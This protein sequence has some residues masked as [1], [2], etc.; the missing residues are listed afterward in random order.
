M[1]ENEAH[2]EELRPRLKLLQAEGLV[3][4]NV[5]NVVRHFD[6]SRPLSLLFDI[7]EKV[8]SEAPFQ[9]VDVI[10]LTKEERVVLKAVVEHLEFTDVA[11]SEKINAPRQVISSMKK[12]LERTGLTK[13][14]RIVDLQK[15]GYDIYAFTDAKFNPEAPLKVRSEG[16]QRTIQ[17]APL[18]ANCRIPLL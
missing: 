11:L 5:K 17:E 6:Y 2:T 12:R 3:F 16:I 8:V 7:K 1:Q 4:R 15:L 9:K 18:R 13:T 14:T 10:R